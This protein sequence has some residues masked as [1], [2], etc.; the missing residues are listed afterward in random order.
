MTDIVY[1]H[2]E[3]TANG[4][5]F[6]TGTQIKVEEIILDYLAYGWDADEIHKQHPS[7]SLAQIHSALAYY[8]DHQE[9]L[10]REIEQGLREV[11]DIKASIRESPARLKLRAKGLLS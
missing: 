4:V 1:A 8:Y 10:D 5:P 6:I 2:I 11:E 7:L 9:E 3:I